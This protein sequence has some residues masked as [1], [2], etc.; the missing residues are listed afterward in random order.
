MK[1]Q[2]ILQAN[3][4]GQIGCRSTDTPCQN[5][6]SVDTI[7]DAQT[8]LFNTAYT[9]DAAAGRDEPIRPVTDRS[10]I[11]T[12]LDSTAPFPAVS[13][14]LLLTSV[15]NEAG[16]AIYGTYPNA[17]PEDAFS[18][19]CQAAFLTT[20]RTNIIIYSPYYRPVSSEDARVQLQTL[21][22]DYLWRCSTWTFARNWVQHGGTAYVGKYLVGATYPGNDAVPYCT[23]PGIVC[24]Q[25]D[26][27]IVVSRPFC[28][29]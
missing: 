28:S 11:T 15:A 3:F 26:I 20:E 2:A 14:S 23:Q 9:L 7:L 17:L 18:P 6:L 10:F 8:N 27:Q 1:T 22:T 19:I 12:P 4:T 25:D 24:H 13:K 29:P 21:G 5:A 16:P